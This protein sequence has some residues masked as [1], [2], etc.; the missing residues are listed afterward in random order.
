MYLTKPTVLYKHITLLF[1]HWANIDAA[2]CCQQDV[3][4]D[5]FLRITLTV[6]EVVGAENWVTTSRP[7]LLHPSS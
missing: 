2:W 4:R 1:V 5:A 3:L 7:L 6:T